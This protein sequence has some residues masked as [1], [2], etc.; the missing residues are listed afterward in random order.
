MF[1]EDLRELK[2]FYLREKEQPKS[3]EDIFIRD[4]EIDKTPIKK[5][6]DSKKDA[7]LDKK[8]FKKKD[9]LEIKRN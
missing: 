7:I 3:K 9:K 1:P 4:I 5:K 2:G 6:G 8:K